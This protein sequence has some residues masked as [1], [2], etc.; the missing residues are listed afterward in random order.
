MLEKKRN[1]SVVNKDIKDPEERMKDF[2]FRNKNYAEVRKVIRDIWVLRNQMLKELEK[3]TISGKKGKD[4]NS[5]ILKNPSQDRIVGSQD[6]DPPIVNP[7]KC[8]LLKSRIVGINN[9]DIPRVQHYQREEDNMLQ[10]EPTYRNIENQPL[11][12]PPQSGLQQRK[13]GDLPQNSPPERITTL[14]NI[15]K[16]W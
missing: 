3:I 9:K 1:N 2:L 14:Q 10:K 13:S 11:S 5:K 16:T 15:L 4:I 12:D 8:G 6:K 7:P